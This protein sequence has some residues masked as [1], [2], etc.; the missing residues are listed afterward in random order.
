M[1]DETIP[2]DITSF[3]SSFLSLFLFTVS[4][5][6]GKYLL[7]SRSRGLRMSTRLP[8][9]QNSP[10]VDKTLIYVYFLHI[11]LLPTFAVCFFFQ[12]YP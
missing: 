3:P 1:A 4:S 7:L 12:I 6:E 9:L 2:R 8:T 11:L 10:L 5:R